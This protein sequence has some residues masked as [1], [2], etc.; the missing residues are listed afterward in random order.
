MSVRSTAAS[1]GLSYPTLLGWLQAVPN[2]FRSVA[3]K[4]ETPDP[5][6]T[7]IRLVTAQGHCVEGLSREDVVFLLQSLP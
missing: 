3:V 5:Q 1:L 4:Q 7:A 2:G 6:A